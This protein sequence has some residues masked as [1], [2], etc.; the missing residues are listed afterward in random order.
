MKISG[1]LKEGYQ[2]NSVFLVI[3][4]PQ[5]PYNYLASLFNLYERGLGVFLGVLCEIRTFLVAR[6]PMILGYKMAFSSIPAD[7]PR[8]KV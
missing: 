7:P 2:V 8:S 3:F 6:N 4:L 5:L 1:E